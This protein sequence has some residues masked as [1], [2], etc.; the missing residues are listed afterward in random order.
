MQIS[1]RARHAL[2]ASL[3]LLLPPTSVLSTPHKYC[4]TVASL[5]LINQPH[6]VTV[7]LSIFTHAI[8]ITAYHHARRQEAG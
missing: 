1:N 4:S 3:G 7:V 8:T 2:K 5:A 6:T